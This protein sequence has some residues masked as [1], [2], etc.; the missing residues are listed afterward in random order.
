[1]IYFKF[2]D[3]ESKLVSKEPVKK[4]PASLKIDPNSINLSYVALKGTTFMRK[5]MLEHKLEYFP[6]EFAF[7]EL[8]ISASD[9]IDSGSV[10]E[11]EPCGSKSLRTSKANSVIG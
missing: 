5:T 6:R 1:M 10:S 8:P 9:D 3:Q 2:F 7:N 11:E 4:F